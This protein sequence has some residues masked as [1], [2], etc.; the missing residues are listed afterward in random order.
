[1]G[2][3]VICSNV[4]RLLWLVSLCSSEDVD[5]KA[6]VKFWLQSHTPSTEP[7][8]SFES[9]ISDYFYPTL[10]WVLSAGNQ[11]VDTTVTGLVVNGHTHVLQAQSKK[12]IVCGLIQGLGGNLTEVKKLS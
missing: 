6:L 9:W 8:P 7:P 5:V 12:K 4:S 1:M 11:K 3:I 10:K 2:C